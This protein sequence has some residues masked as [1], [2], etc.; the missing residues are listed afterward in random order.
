V[1]APESRIIAVVASVVLVL[2]TLSPVLR[3]N[4]Y[5]DSFPLSTYPMF[6]SVRPREVK[7][8]YALG[9]TATG[10]RRMLKPRLI[11][12][13]EILQAFTTIARAVAAGPGEQQKLCRAIAERVRSSDRDDIVA[14]RIVT[15]THDAID[16]LTDD[17]LGKERELTRCPVKR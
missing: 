5:D 7:L 14:I 13:G 3:K 9:V 17:K 10:E 1:T 11:G 15:G 8:S 12:S 6:A 16:L 2:M 4:P